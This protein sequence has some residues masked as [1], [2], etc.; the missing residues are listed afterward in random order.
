MSAVLKG[1]SDESPGWRSGKEDMT[2]QL[3]QGRVGWKEGPGRW[4]SGQDEV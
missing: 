4:D 2:M 1:Q 3:E